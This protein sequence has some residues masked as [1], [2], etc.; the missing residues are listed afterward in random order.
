MVAEKCMPFVAKPTG[1]GKN[2]YFKSGSYISEECAQK[3]LKNPSQ[4][5]AVFSPK[6]S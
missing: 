5:G 2:V 6:R 1:N 4:L 3:N